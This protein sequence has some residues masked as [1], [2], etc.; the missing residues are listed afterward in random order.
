MGARL[1]RQASAEQPTTYKDLRE[2]FLAIN[3]LADGSSVTLEQAVTPLIPVL[4]TIETY[5]RLV[6]QKCASPADGLTPDES[7]AVMLYSMG[8]QPLNECLYIVLNT[9]L[10]SM[11]R[12]S[13]E[14]WSPY[15][16]LLLNAAQRLPSTHLTVY[17]ENGGDLSAQY[18]AGE[19]FTWW[20]FSLCAT[21]IDRFR[22]AHTVFAIE[23]HAVKDIRKHTYTS[24]DDTVLI[25]PGT[26]F[27]VLECSSGSIGIREVQPSFLLQAV[28]ET[29]FPLL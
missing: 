7:A 8:W 5:A 15:M 16:K 14:P 17:R 12:Q 24:T 13:L 19:Q 28:S 29:E 11:N 9:T 2:Y 23:S 4:P 6:K 20:D 1:A 3:S 18:V 27:Q 25:L 21:S 26:R 22:A 10:R